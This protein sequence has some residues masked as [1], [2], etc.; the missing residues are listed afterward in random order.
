MLICFSFTVVT[1]ATMIIKKNE[2][3]FTISIKYHL[4]VRS[5]DLLHHCSQNVICDDGA[6]SD[7][8]RGQNGQVCCL[9]IHI[10]QC[11]V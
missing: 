6:V 4:K 1:I 10:F 2:L 3:S 7:L 5:L 8:L 9:V 11:V